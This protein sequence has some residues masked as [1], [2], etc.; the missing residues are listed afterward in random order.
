[1]NFGS[2]YEFLEPLMKIKI[3]KRCNLA[4][5]PK[6]LLAGWP[7]GLC[8]P[9][10]HW[11]EERGL[12]RGNGGPATPLRPKALPGRVVARHW[13]RAAPSGGAALRAG[14][15]WRRWVREGRG[16]WR[17]LLHVGINRRLLPSALARIDR[18]LL[19]GS[20]VGSC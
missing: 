14:R 10:F 20:T 9:V 15:H 16:A 7:D 5:G 13:Q 3:W 1:M 19:L 4:T 12:S 18:R 6:W 11:A 8:G 2:S 17:L